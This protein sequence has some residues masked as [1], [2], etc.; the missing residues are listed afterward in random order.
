MYQLLWVRLT[1]GEV[2][3]VNEAWDDM[4]VLQLVVVVWSVDIGG[5]DTGEGTA[6]L[7]MV[8]PV[9]QHSERM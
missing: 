1:F 8:R 7:G 2:A 4:A 9:C 6:M 5:D 3:L